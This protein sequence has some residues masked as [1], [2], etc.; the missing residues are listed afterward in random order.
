[1]L[2]YPSCFFFLCGSEGYQYCWCGTQGLYLCSGWGSFCLLN[3]YKAPYVPVAFCFVIK[4]ESEEEIILINIRNPKAPKLVFQIE[5]REHLSSFSDHSSR[6]TGKSNLMMDKV[7]QVQGA[8]TWGSIGRKGK[9]A[10]EIWGK[11][12]GKRD[13]QLLHLL[14]E[15][16]DVKGW[17]AAGNEQFAPPQ[18]SPSASCGVPTGKAGS[19]AAASFL[20]HAVSCV[21]YL[22]LELAGVA[23]M[24]C[25][26][27]AK[28]KDK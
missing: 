28:K 26:I 2:R 23:R 9:A 6:I 18:L 15:G 4:V 13:L 17:D 21:P 10:K 5:L 19:K 14:R 12:C 8:P 20:P 22:S 24:A 27:L 3:S 25:A 16:R 7:E 11:T 1:M